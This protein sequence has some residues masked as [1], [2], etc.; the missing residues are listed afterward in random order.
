M[1]A[2]PCL[3]AMRMASRVSETVPIWL[4]FTRRALQALRLMAFE[5]L[6]GLVVSRSSP[7]IWISEPIFSSISLHASQSSWAKGSSMETTGYASTSLCQ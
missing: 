3:K 7:T 2:K 4:G 1:A 5:I 6:E